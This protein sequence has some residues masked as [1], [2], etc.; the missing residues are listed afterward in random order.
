MRLSESAPGKLP[1]RIPGQRRLI[2]VNA[3]AGR[4]WQTDGAG[5]H[6]KGRRRNF[7][8]PLFEVDEILG[9][10]KVS[11]ESTNILTSINNHNCPEVASSQGSN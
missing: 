4:G 5:F 9:D 1:I 7:L 11:V 10:E 3:Q 8:S 6:L 2:Q